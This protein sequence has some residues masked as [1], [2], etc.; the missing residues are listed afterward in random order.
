MVRDRLV[1]HAVRQAYSDVLFHGRH[2]AYVLFLEL[3]PVLVDVNVHPTKREVRFL[4]ESAL[5][6]SLVRAVQAQ[7]RNLVPGWNLNPKDPG[8]GRPWDPRVDGLDAR[9]GGMDQPAGRPG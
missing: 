9:G 7:T 6:G 8:S 4:D 5:F 3:D 2:P 1:T